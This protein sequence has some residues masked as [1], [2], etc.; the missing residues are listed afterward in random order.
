MPRQNRTQYTIMGLLSIGEMS[1]YDIK[2]WVEDYLSF[3]WNESWG[4]IYPTLKKLEND[5][6]ISDVSS[7]SDARNKRIYALTPQGSECLKEYLRLPPAEEM[8]RNE[9]LLKLFFGKAAGLDV[10]EK[11]IKRELQRQRDIEI[12][13]QRVSDDL[14]QCEDNGDDKYWKYGLMFGKMY[15][16]MVI[17]WCENV[18]SDIR[19]EMNKR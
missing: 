11:H 4:Q 15:N 8:M 10:I 19:T 18:L 6:M 5:G 17:D 13:R 16:R 3:F 12:C 9:L 7:G 2:R 14:D 1:G